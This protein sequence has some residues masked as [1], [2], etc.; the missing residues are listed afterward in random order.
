MLVLRFVLFLLPVLAACLPTTTHAQ[1]TDSIP[2]FAPIGAKWYYTYNYYKEY[3]V[4]CTDLA[5]CPNYY[6]KYE[7][8]H[9]TLIH[10]TVAKVMKEFRF[11]SLAYDTL[12][13]THRHYL[14]QKNKTLYVYNNYFFDTLYSFDLQNNG[15]YHCQYP[16]EPLIPRAEYKFKSIHS[17]DTVI[18]GQVYRMLH[19]K[20]SRNLQMYGYIGPVIY[21]VGN[22]STSFPYSEIDDFDYARFEL[23][24]F[25]R[26]GFGDYLYFSEKC[27]ISLNPDCLPNSLSSVYLQNIKVYKAIDGLIFSK[28]FTGI[29]KIE[30]YDLFGNNVPFSCLELNCEDNNDCMYLKLPANRGLHFIVLSS[31]SRKL[32][33]KVIL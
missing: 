27:Y 2:E 26:T 1:T 9:D 23:I 32:V 6:M 19:I 4:P 5:N 17:S 7:I 14:Y 3:N 22:L 20:P 12:V 25:D 8:T 10:D 15:T 29:A 33:Y 24:A 21:G 28:P 30:V 18:N 16:V 13:E 11:S 31:N